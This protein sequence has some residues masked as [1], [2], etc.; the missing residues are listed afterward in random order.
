MS[1]ELSFRDFSIA[2]LAVRAWN[3]PVSETSQAEVACLFLLHGR[4]CT[5][6]MVEPF[7]KR[8]I[9]HAN[10]LPKQAAKHLIVITF[11]HRNHGSRLHSIAAN[12]AWNTHPNMPGTPIEN[13][14]HAL[15]MYAIQTGTAEDI[16]MLI[17][18]I[19]SYL[20]PERANPITAWCV[21]GISLGG[22]SAWLSG[23]MDQRVK[24]VIPI[25]GSPDYETLMRHR[26]ARSRP[27]IPFAPPHF[28]DALVE[29]V[30][31]KDP[32]QAASSVWNGKNLLV[33][34][35][36]VDKLVN[37]IDSGASAFIDRLKTQANLQSIEVVVEDGA[38]HELTESMILKTCD[39][40][41]THILIKK[42]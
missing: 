36:S 40:V 29:L 9:E 26:A 20:Y 4:L 38:G 12:H 28:P 30:R 2:G 32:C 10:A 25:I 15:D 8:I 22:H 33:L 39:W 13:P 1:K 16:S 23:A 42:S 31:R 3:Y 34:S 21:A 19:P 18:F 35:G 11:D 6:A 24:Y 37:F 27:A 7:T 17:D 14:T 41:S 5:S